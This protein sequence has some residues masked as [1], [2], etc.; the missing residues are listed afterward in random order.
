MKL[1]ST[2][3]RTVVVEEKVKSEMGEK[4]KYKK[5]RNMPETTNNIRWYTCW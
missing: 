5:G 4:I 1:Y 2:V 3:N